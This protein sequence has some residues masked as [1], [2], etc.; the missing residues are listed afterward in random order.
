M[1]VTSVLDADRIQS[2]Y[3]YNYQLK[4]ALGFTK[5]LFIYFLVITILLIGKFLSLKNKIKLKIVNFYC[6]ILL[7]LMLYYKNVRIIKNVIRFK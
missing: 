7:C 5:I 3:L 4:A 1:A 6:V 2:F